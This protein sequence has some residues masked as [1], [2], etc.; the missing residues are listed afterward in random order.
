[1][2]TIVDKSIVV[3]FTKTKTAQSCQQT[4]PQQSMKKLY[5]DAFFRRGVMMIMS[6]VE[7]VVYLLVGS[8][9]QSIV[10]DWQ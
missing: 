7:V 8:N 6:C 2:K 5:L 4:P 9:R 10:A 3:P 1:M